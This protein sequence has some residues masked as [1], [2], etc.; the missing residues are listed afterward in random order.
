MELA[1]L[2][3]TSLP[4][5][6]DETRHLAESASV[7]LGKSERFLRL[8]MLLLGKNKLFRFLAELKVEVIEGR[9]PHNRTGTLIWR[10]LTEISQPVRASH[11][12][13]SSA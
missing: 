2:L 7:D 12:N 10:L 1:K 11:L 3:R 5:L 4:D 9:G 13:A 8:C 6:P